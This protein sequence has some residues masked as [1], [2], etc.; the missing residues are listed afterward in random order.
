MAFTERVNS[1]GNSLYNDDRNLLRIRE[2]ERRNQ[3]AHQ[4]KEAFPE[5]IPLFGEPYKTAK[6]DE[7]SS[8]IQNMLG[9]YEEVKEFLST[10]SHTH[11]LDAPE[12]RLGKPKYPLIPDK[13]SSIPSSSFHTSVHHQSI[14]TPA[15]GPLS[16]GNISHNPKMA[17]PRTEPMPSLHAKSCGPPDSQHLTQDRLGQEGFGS[18]H[19]KK[20]DRRADGDH[21]A[22]VTDSAPEREPSPLISSLPSP[23]P[24]LSPIHSNQQTLPRTQ[25]S[26]KVH[27]S[28]N[29]SKGCCP[30]KSPKDLA[31]KVH[32]K[33]T[34]QDSLVAPAQPPSQTFPPP[35]LPSKSVAMQQKPTAYVRPMDG[36]DQ[37]PSESPELKP[38]PEDYRQQ[39]FEKTDLK[40]PA[41][42]K[43]T[44]L[45]MPSQSVEQT[46][47]NEVH[48]V[49][50]ILKDSQHVSSVTQNQ[51]QYDTSSKT[52]SNSQQ[53][54]SSMLEDDL[55][56]SDS[57]DS[58]SEQ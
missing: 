49:E 25:G 10:K 17:Q 20:G 50:E 4:E 24:P 51:K 36:Q 8:R 6:G 34:P 41:K 47:S 18:S 23:V 32:D 13:G 15:S 42:A 54:T 22:S 7:L 28:N 38:L 9:N 57:E 56:L 55:Q 45:K 44:K 11:R 31:V 21:C 37:A 58:D 46:Y 40:V 53:G 19:H 39:T 33:E 16:V 3:E 26:S 14:H 1:S 12:N 2:K 27:G 5:K 29:N 30:A 43:L 48:C 52:H 35:S